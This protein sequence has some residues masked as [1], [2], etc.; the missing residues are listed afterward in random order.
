MGGEI[1]YENSWV[2]VKKLVPKF[3]PSRDICFFLNLA[4]VVVQSLGHICL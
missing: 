1:G 3:E 4:V 2:Q